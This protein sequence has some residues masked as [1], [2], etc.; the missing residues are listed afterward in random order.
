M[1]GRTK[2]WLHRP[3]L[4]CSQ[5]SLTPLSVPSRRW[6]LGH[7]PKPSH[8]PWMSPTQYKMRNHFVMFQK[9]LTGDLIEPVLNLSNKFERR[10]HLIT[11]RQSLTLSKYVTSF[12]SFIQVFL[13]LPWGGFAIIFIG[14]LP[15]LFRVILC[16]LLLLTELSPL[17]FLLLFHFFIVIKSLHILAWR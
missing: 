2:Q 6:T 8:T 11:F 13:S 1:R 17:S 15:K 12:Y 14:A 7:V 9:K 5:S 3:G 10:D 4:S 16:F